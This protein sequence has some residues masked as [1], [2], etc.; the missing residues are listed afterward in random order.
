[1]QYVLPSASLVSRSAFVAVGGFDETLSGYEDDDLFV[2]VFRAGFRHVYIDEPLSAWRIHSK[3]SSYT[4]RMA[5]SRIQFA[6]KLLNM[7]PD[8]EERHRRYSRDCIAPR[9]IHDIINDLSFAAKKGQT[10]I[11][12]GGMADIETL[13]P[14]LRGLRRWKL[15]LGLNV[16]RLALI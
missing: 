2:R 9:F 11:M 3:S 7:I 6:H 4:F 14:H 13:L 10:E 8:D 12:K 5:R 1:N 16:G 15:R